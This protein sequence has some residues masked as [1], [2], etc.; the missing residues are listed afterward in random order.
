MM[1][2]YR[3]SNP[4]Q[5]YCR[6]GFL[7][8]YVSLD[9]IGA[10]H[11]CGWLGCRHTKQ[12]RICCGGIEQTMCSAEPFCSRQCGPYNGTSIYNQHNSSKG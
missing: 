10:A 5:S 8:C 1:W 6:F 9:G 11:W 2:Q 3:V 7:D 4:R 12:T